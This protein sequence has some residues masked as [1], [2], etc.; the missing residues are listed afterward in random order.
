MACTLASMYRERVACRNY[1]QQHLQNYVT[2]YHVHAEKRARDT[3]RPRDLRAGCMAVVQAHQAD[4]TGWALLI[5]QNHPCLPLLHIWQYGAIF[6]K[7]PGLRWPSDKNRSTK[8][9]HG[10]QYQ[11]QLTTESGRSPTR[12]TRRASALRSLLRSR[13]SATGS[14]SN[15]SIGKTRNRSHAVAGVWNCKFWSC[16]S[17][18]CKPLR[19]GPSKKAGRRR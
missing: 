10:G 8:N 18:E 3:Y 11:R 5:S 15:S 12:V 19:V 6:V 4:P 7:P 9:A 16:L 2:R 1:G 14:S 13:G 17:K